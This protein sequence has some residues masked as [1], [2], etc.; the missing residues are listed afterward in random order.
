[1][2]KRRAT[3]PLHTVEEIIAAVKALSDRDERQRFLCFL[4]EILSGSERRYLFAACPE[5]HTLCTDISYSREG[6]LFEQEW[7]ETD[8]Q[9]APPDSITEADLMRLG[10]GNPLEGIA[11]ANRRCKP[12]RERLRAAR[13]C[14]NARKGKTKRRIEAIDKAIEAGVTKEEVY[15]FMKEHHGDLI[16][17]RK[18]KNGRKEPFMSEEK[19]WRSYKENGGKR[20][21]LQ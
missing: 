7:R 1:M 17:G 20:A 16:P 15:K 3:A 4:L 11:F 2:S 14:E 9:N 6:C 10:S 13:N 21:L 18:K 5:S 19:M 8:A 12:L